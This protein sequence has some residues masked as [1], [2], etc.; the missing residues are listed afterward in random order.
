MRL[1]CSKTMSFAMSR[2][3]RRRHRWIGAKHVVAIDHIEHATIEAADVVLPTATFAEA[4]GTLVN[5][6]GRAQRFFRCSLPPAR[7][8]RAG[9]GCDD[10]MRVQGRPERANAGRTSTGSPRHWPKRCPSSSPC[11]EIARNADFRLLGQKIPRQPHRYSGRTAMHA[12]RD[13]NEPQPPADDDS[14]LAFSMEGFAR[15]TSAR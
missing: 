3:S 4:D 2:R 9:S 6:E 12:N 15:P 13:V 7:F 10:I 11:T 14:P 1:S 8:A 5:Y